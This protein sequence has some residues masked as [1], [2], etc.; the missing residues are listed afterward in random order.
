M[1]CDLTLGDLRELV[2]CELVDCE[3]REREKSNIKSTEDVSVMGGAQQ[4]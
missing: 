3:Y 1:E 2:D 4:H